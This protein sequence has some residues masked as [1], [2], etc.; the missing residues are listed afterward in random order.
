MLDLS[1]NRIG[2]DGFDVCAAAAAAGTALEG[3]ALCSNPLKHIDFSECAVG[4]EEVKCLFDTMVQKEILPNV[5]ELC[6][7]DNPQIWW[8]LLQ[9]EQHPN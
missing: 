4:C 9:R 7:E 1:W 6:L 5:E 3:G 2:N 8:M